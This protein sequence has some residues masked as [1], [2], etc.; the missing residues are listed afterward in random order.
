MAVYQKLNRGKESQLLVPFSL[1][2]YS[3]VQITVS[4]TISENKNHFQGIN[5]TILPAIKIIFEGTY[6]RNLLETIYK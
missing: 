1:K 3:T 4:Q 2:L 6:D 5:P